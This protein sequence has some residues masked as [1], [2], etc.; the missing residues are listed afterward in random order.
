MI[1]EMSTELSVVYAKVDRLERFLAGAG[2]VDAAALVEY[3]LPPEALAAQDDW[4][5]L[6]IERLYSSVRQQTAS[7]ITK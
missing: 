1:L 5:N 2:V 3:E 4:R 7:A 6:F